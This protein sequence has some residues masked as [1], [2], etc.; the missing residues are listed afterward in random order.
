M[1]VRKPVLIRLAVQVEFAWSVRPCFLCLTTHHRIAWK[2][3]ICDTR[4]LNNG[5]K[6]EVLFVR[7]LLL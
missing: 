7:S 5:Q 1:P 6:P 2:K 4:L 3:C